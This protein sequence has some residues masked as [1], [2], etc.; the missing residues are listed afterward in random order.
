MASDYVKS[1]NIH[2]NQHQ[3][4]FNWC[5]FM[6]HPQK[7]LQKRYVTQETKLQVS[8]SLRRSFYEYEHSGSKL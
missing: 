2:I 7:M 8:T 4:D 3:F 5:E 1:G 6:G